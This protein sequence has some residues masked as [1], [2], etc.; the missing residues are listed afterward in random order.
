MGGNLQVKWISVLR[1]TSSLHE[2]NQLIKNVKID[3][4]F[5]EKCCKARCCNDGGCRPRGG[6]SE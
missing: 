1:S 5:F 2:N 4:T 3:I 6:S